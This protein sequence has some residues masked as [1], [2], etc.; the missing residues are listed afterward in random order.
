MQVHVRAH[1][2]TDARV[3]AQALHAISDEGRRAREN[4]ERYVAQAT[5]S[6]NEETMKRP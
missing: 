3:R 6:R 4:A 5:M 1:A 2:C